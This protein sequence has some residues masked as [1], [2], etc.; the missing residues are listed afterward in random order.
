MSLQQLKYCCIILCAESLYYPG[1]QKL[2]C[3]SFGASSPVTSAQCRCLSGS[4][5]TDQ[6]SR[7]SLIDLKGKPLDRLNHSI[8][9]VQIFYV[10]HCHCDFSIPL[11]YAVM[12]CGLAAHPRLFPC[13]STSPEFSTVS[14][15]QIPETSRISAQSAESSYEM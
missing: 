7:L 5:R 11:R 14:S 13:A 15:S 1:L 3:P 12:T 4:V 2:H 10:K 8:I 6:R 9:Y